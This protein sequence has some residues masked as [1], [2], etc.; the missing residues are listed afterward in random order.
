MLLNRLSIQWK[1]S[2]LAGLC[3]LVIVAALDGAALLQARS[4]AELVKQSS[5]QMLEGIAKQRLQ[6]LAQAQAASVQR[7]FMD[8]YLYA[9]GFSQQASLMRAQAN[10]HGIAAADLRK[11]LS[12]QAA[13]ALN[14]EITRQ[15]SM[16]AYVD[17]FWLMMIATL[18]VI[19]LLLLIKPPAKTA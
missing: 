17:D 18:C 12:A 16:I 9:Q 2:L 10:T 1:I 19:P 14:N 3:L 13:A 7:Y 4:S 15:A 5:S 8:A 11:E 6:A